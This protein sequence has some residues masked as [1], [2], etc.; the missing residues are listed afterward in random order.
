[1][2]VIKVVIISSCI[3]VFTTTNYLEMYQKLRWLIWDT[4]KDTAIE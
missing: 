1:V 3:L 2:W 4:V